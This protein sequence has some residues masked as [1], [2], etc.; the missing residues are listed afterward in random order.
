TFGPLITTSE[1][2]LTRVIQ[3]DVRVVW[4]AFPP[5]DRIELD[6]VGAL[7]SGAA[8]LPDRVSFAIAGS[9]PTASTS[10]DRILAD[11]E[12]SLLVSRTGVLLL[13]VQLAILAAYAIV[14]TAG[15]LA[16]HRRL[17]T[18][19]LRSRG[20][21]A[22]QVASM[23]LAEALVLAAPAAVLAPFL[24]AG[25]LTLF[26]VAGPLSAAQIQIHPQLS[27]TAFLVAAA[28]ALGA[29]LLLVV[30]AFI[31]ARSFA[32]EEGGR[33][34]FETRTIGQRLGV[35]IALLAV[36]AI[37]FWQLR[38]YGAPLTESVQGSLGLDPLLVAAPA[39]GLLAGGVLAL[40]IVPLLAQAAEALTR[41]GRR[42]IGSLGAQQMA[43]RPLRYTRS[44]LL[45][46]LAVSMGVFA[47][48]YAE[49]WQSSQ[50]DQAAYEVGA[51]LRVVAP[52][53]A[54]NVP[55]WAL[56][57][58]LGRLDGVESVMG[59]D[60][61]SLRLPGGS[62][63]GVLLGVDPNRAPGIVNLRPDL[64]SAPLDSLM[65]PLTA[66]RPAPAFIRFDTAPA[67]LRISTQVALTRVFGFEFDPAAGAFMPN[68]RDPAELL[69]R[70]IVGAEVVV[71]DASGSISRFT[72]APQPLQPGVQQVE[73]PLSAGLDR[74]DSAIAE[75][76]GGFTGSLEL[77]SIDITVALPER[78]IASG[79]SVELA[80]MSASDGQGGAWHTVDL[81][82]AGGWSMW[83]IRNQGPRTSPAGQQV[84]GR[85][86]LLDGA[87]STGTLVGARTNLRPPALSF[88]AASLSSLVDASVPAV[89]NRAFLDGTSARVGDEV[90]VRLDGLVRRVEI[91]DTLESFPTE[92]PGRPLAIADL[93]SL[94][95]IRFAS[96]QSTQAPREW[97]VATDPGMGSRVA[98]LV[99]RGPY[100]QG[101]ILSR[102]DRSR[103]LS[104]DPVALGII[105][106]LS[107]GFVVA[108]L[109]A[110]IGLVVSAAVSA[111]QRRTEF[112]L[113]RALGLSS[114]QLSGWLWL[115]NAAVVI[116]SL[117][118]GVG[119]GLLIGWVALPFVTVTQEATAP[120]PPP[121]VR[122][123]WVSIGV[124]VAVSAL[125]L[126][127]TVL[128]LARVLR[129][130][131]IG[132]VLRM[133]ED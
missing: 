35:D 30:P 10:L 123:P 16:D 14:L 122:T 15:L 2:L 129:R 22:T 99:E 103:A 56:E 8:E 41:R 121:L 75:I 89:V 58:A 126:G 40:R 44:A 1:D 55:A 100:A 24:A 130:I 43:R 5:F 65:E 66:A 115:E 33:S 38:L 27:E 45:L 29:S 83:V 49:T 4:H 69:G 78:W 97:W 17:D 62:R 21:G 102:D 28:A 11:A 105:G 31:A 114:R 53:G 77:L 7:R 64:S 20:A 52:G 37:G 119:L 25:A 85:S 47:I 104:S 6:Q 91:A 81:D 86:L 98:D 60:R 79:G 96:T 94:G 72:T 131:G 111:R 107:L 132:S 13:I 109:F 117:L 63:Q 82:A 127:V 36:T 90:T 113:L 124:L 112:A 110:A 42:L 118:A 26:N 54:G 51:D 74:T 116:V 12:R 34:R 3:G 9:F 39:I 50:Q 46:M 59:V 32:E 80:G 73:I 68:P 70:R 87:G 71:R 92:E 48:S 133:G 18:A 61:Q 88:M 108:G 23:A 101:P 120:F 106:A 125:S 84:Q 19:L 95:L 128:V 57:S 76:G 67:A 93:S